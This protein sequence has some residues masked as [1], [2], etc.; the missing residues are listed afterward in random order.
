VLV[1]DVGSKEVEVT[2][3]VIYDQLSNDEYL[4][5]KE[6]SYSIS[7]GFVAIDTDNTFSSSEILNIAD[8]RMYESKKA[9]K[10]ARLQETL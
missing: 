10:K 3:A 7:F 2:S 1:P 9:R 4:S 6:Y 5:G 8:E